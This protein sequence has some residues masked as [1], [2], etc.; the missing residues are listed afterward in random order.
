[1]RE[2]NSNGRMVKVC[3]CVC[4]EVYRPWVWVYV[5][6]KVCVANV[7]MVFVPV[8]GGIRALC[9]GVHMC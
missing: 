6:V 3:V 8:C 5:C 1:M 4:V 7:C 9:V 2:L